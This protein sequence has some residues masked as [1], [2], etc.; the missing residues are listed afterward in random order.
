MTYKRVMLTEFGGPEALRLETASAL[1]EPG[2]GELRVRVLSAGTGFTDT[3]IRQGQ[4][5]G[6]K[7]R[8]P[9]VPGYDWF[10]VVDKLG[11][12]VTD[13]E[14]GQHVADMPVIGGYTQYLCVNA[15][16]AVPAPAGLDPAS[17]VAM[18]L[19]YTTA[20][21]MLTRIRPLPK[22]AT[23]LVHAAGGAVGSALLE[24]G[25]LAGLK[26]YGTASA[27][28]HDLVRS[29][30]GI[31][32]DYR[33]EDFVSR[34][35][36][37]TGGTG[38]DAVFDTIGGANWARSYQCVKRGG[39]LV[40]FGALQLTTGEEKVPALLWGFFKLLAGWRL[41]PDGRATTFYNIQT[42]REKH[43]E[44]FREDLSS[45]F[46]LLK[47]GKLQP[48]IHSIRP[49]EDVVEVHRQIDAGDIAGKVV[50]DC[51]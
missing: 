42:R 4:Y 41:I 17:A 50:L 46:A 36:D 6:V 2:P 43:P 34:V 13:F 32:I 29:F 10:G 8:P 20:F 19:S 27:K 40:G 47:A 23:C 35:L 11:V 44:E 5:T 16:K 37:E 48:A 39:I 7:E 25:K 31:P 51:A 49:L 24:L 21:Q 33:N 26:M 38:V 15:D 14:V 9:F 3:I 28:K 30:D 1:P 18:I 12:G 45:L 22:G